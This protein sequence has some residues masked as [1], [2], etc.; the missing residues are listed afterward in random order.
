M[1]MYEFDYYFTEVGSQDSIYTNS[2]ALVQTMTW[3]RPGDKL[4]SESM[5]IILMTHTFVTRPQ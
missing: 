3:R 2:P 5:M 1:K 4:L